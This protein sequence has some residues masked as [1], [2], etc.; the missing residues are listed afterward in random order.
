MA[1]L[2]R[3]GL[4]QEGRSLGTGAYGSVAGLCRRARPLLMPRLKLVGQLNRLKRRG[5]VRRRAIRSC[6]FAMKR[7]SLVDREEFQREVSIST[8]MGR[9]RIGPH[10]FYA[11]IC[12]IKNV[13][14]GAIIMERFDLTLEKYAK[15]YPS[16]FSRRSQNLYLKLASLLERMHAKGIVHRD[17]HSGNILLNLD[18]HGYPN[19]VV[20]GDWGL[21]RWSK[22]IKAQTDDK[23]NLLEIFQSE[24]NDANH[25]IFR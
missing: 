5:H 13:P 24:A 18:K 25:V 8:L 3:L 4:I 9:L 7:V 2:K 11:P 6:R 16:H 1:C 10:I 15:T 12:K 22:N 17:L 14:Y 19:K 23:N 20:I 21:A